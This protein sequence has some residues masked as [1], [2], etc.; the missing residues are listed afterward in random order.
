MATN[1]TS[2]YQL[3]QW[4]PDDQVNR[5]EFNQDNSRIEEGLVD[6]LGKLDEVKST[7][8]SNVA[9]LEQQINQVGSNLS[10][11]E[12]SISTM[13][14]NIKTVQTNVSSLQSSNTTIN[15]SLSTVQSNV[16][17]LQSSVTTLQSSVSSLQSNVS[18]L[19]SDYTTMNTS[20]SSTSTKAESAYSLASTAYSPTNSN[21]MLAY[22]TGTGSNRYISFGFAAKVAFVVEESGNMNTTLNAISSSYVN[23]VDDDETCSFQYPGCFCMTLGMYASGDFNLVGK[24]YLVMMFR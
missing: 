23:N 13:D 2:N 1:Y 20:L 14:A 21:I 22:Y 10:T 17:T 5:L 3:C 18:T 9:S 6:L 24:R 11:M 16:S 7:I 8:S 4:E 12:A 19:Q 15:S